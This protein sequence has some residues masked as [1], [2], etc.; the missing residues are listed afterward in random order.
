M[1][2][3]RRRRAWLLALAIVTIGCDRVT[4]HVAT[5]ALQGSPRLSFL[6][7][8]VRL[9]Y[10]ENPGGFL[11][12]GARLPRGLRVLLFQV[13]AGLALAAALAIAVSQPLPPHARIALTL[14][15]AGGA[16]NL[17]DRALAGSVVDF[18]NVGIGGLRSGIFNVADLAISIGLVLAV[19]RPAPREP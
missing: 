14:V 16:S 11:G 8:T 4:K 6:N 12:L 19:W 17:A 5:S 9:E 13:G 3:A 2:S 1:T 7:D 18:L 15:C 10:A